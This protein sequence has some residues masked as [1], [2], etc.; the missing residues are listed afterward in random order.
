MQSNTNRCKFQWYNGIPNENAK[1]H[2]EMVERLNQFLVNN[3]MTNKNLICD[4]SHV[5]LFLNIVRCMEM[6]IRFADSIFF[7][8]KNIHNRIGIQ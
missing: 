6:Q 2:L 3:T 5:F 8:V 7:S 1:R 4:E